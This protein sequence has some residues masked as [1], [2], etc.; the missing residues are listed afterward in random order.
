MAI[1]KVPDSRIKHKLRK[2][3]YKV[4]KWQGE[5]L[6]F[7]MTIKNAMHITIW[8]NKSILMTFYNLGMPSPN[9]CSPRPEIIKHIYN[10]LK[11]NETEDIIQKPPVRRR[12]R[13][14]GG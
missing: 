3:K 1:I 10:I 11:A 2:Q 9:D 12:N 14:T 5:P 6:K 13:S 7:D 4:L 8:I